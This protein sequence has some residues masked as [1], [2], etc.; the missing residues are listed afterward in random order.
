MRIRQVHQRGRSVGVAGALL[1]GILTSGAH[2]AGARTLGEPL[3]R[4]SPSAIGSEFERP[5]SE[6]IT[7]TSSEGAPLAE[8]AIRLLC[9]ESIAAETPSSTHER[10][11]DAGGVIAR[12]ADCDAAIALWRI[13][14]QPSGK[15]GRSGDGHPAYTVYKR[16]GGR[17]AAIPHA[18]DGPTVA[19]G[20]EILV[21]FDVVVSLEFEPAPEY[22]AEIED[23][24]K[25]VSGL[26]YQATDGQ[27]A[28]GDIA[29]RTSGERWDAA[30]IQVLAADN[31]RPAAYPCGIVAADTPIPTDEAR[32]RC[33]P[34]GTILLPRYWNGETAADGSWNEDAGART[35]LHEWAHY[36]LMLFDAYKGPGGPAGCRSARAPSATLMDRLSLEGF[37]HA[38]FHGAVTPL[39]ETCHET[40]QWAVH[41][42]HDWATLMRWF[43]LQGID[44]AG[45][46][47]G[48]GDP[49]LSVALPEA[50]GSKLAV[51]DRVGA[52]TGSVCGLHSGATIPLS[53]S[54]LLPIAAVQ[55]YTRHGARWMLQGTAHQAYTRSPFTSEATVHLASELVGCDTVDEVRIDADVGGHRFLGSAVLDRRARA[56]LSVPLLPAGTWPGADVDHG[57][58]G[59]IRLDGLDPATTRVTGSSPGDLGGYAPGEDFELESDAGAIIVRP[60]SG[61]RFPNWFLMRVQ[62]ALGD[63]ITYVQRGGGVGPASMPAHAPIRDGCVMVDRAPPLDPN[64]NPMSSVLLTRAN[65]PPLRQAPPGFNGIMVGTAVDVS[66][67]SSAASR[68]PRTTLRL[69]LCYDAPVFKRR[70][71]VEGRLAVVRLNP[72]PGRWDR[73]RTVTGAEAPQAILYEQNMISV[74]IN[75]DGIY[76][77]GWKTLPTP[78][79]TATRTATM[80][81]TPTPTPT[82]GSTGTPTP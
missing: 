8:Q 7:F 28:F 25:R 9:Y 79:P 14:R 27:M 52:E 23:A 37:I 6:T 38:P 77:I 62:T 72:Q 10:M 3:S 82:T 60:R 11:T 16:V 67:A 81:P 13:H 53:G 19:L 39:P 33:S 15:P 74:P 35:I 2:L 21:L 50:Y 56:S 47:A 63:W 1:A 46:G 49:D 57:L 64:L 55:V 65:V 31:V 76:A 12:P 66:I 22:L 26:L 71:I 40:D 59:E 34:A 54:D 36:A 24:M 75:E 20:D 30:D 80:T 61:H 4:W 68:S 45:V 44:I 17:H 73:I 5:L 41:D 78:T 48:L 58:D 69:T 29:I 43:A 42:E 18:I 32:V 51:A 70:G